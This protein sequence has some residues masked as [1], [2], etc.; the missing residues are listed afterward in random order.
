[1]KV[2]GEIDKPIVPQKSC[3]INI[4][5]DVS[6][7]QRHIFRNYILMADPAKVLESGRKYLKPSLKQ[8]VIFGKDIPEGFEDCPLEIPTSLEEE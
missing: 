7:S 4:L 2:L 8:R 1:M 5:K 3:L 6:N